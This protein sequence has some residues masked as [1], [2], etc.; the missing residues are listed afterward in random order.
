MDTSESHER[1][2]DVIAPFVANAQPAVLMQPAE[3]A[4]H[5]PADRSEPRLLVGPAFGNHRF[6]STNAQEQ[7]VSHRV[8]RFVRKQALRTSARPST[9]P[10]HRRNGINQGK[11]LGY[12]GD[13]GRSERCR[14]GNAI[15]I[16]DDVVFRTAF[17]PIGGI[18]AGFDPPKTARTLELSATARDQSIL[19]ACRKWLSRT[20]WRSIHTPACCQSRSRLQQVMP[21]PQPNSWGK[22]SHGI[23]VRRT[24]RIPVSVLRLSTGLRPGYRNRRLGSGR[25]GSIKAHKSSGTISFAIVGPP[26][27]FLASAKYATKEHSFC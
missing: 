9:F 15:R 26:C 3:G 5:D 13:I 24:K 6:N 20:W 27:P 11:Q 14:Q 12:V 25:I 21:D 8:V 2:V 16:R 23:P 17:R 4:F 19:S 1:F 10:L 22:S 18:G 7:A